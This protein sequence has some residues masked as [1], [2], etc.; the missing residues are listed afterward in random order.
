MGKSV[1]DGNGGSVGG[2]G[3]GGK[4][5][6][7]DEGVDREC[8]RSAS[9]SLEEEEKIVSPGRREITSPGTLT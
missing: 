2:V 3:A 4:R 1:S 6:R 7:S 5:G 9:G 8:R